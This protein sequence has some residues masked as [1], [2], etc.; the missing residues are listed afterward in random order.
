MELF[1][2]AT[3]FW[4]SEAITETKSMLAL[5]LVKMLFA[6]EKQLS[7]YRQRIEAHFE[8]HPDHDLFDSLTGAGPSW[9]L[10]CLPRSATILTCNRRTPIRSNPVVWR[11]Y[12][13]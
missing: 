7:E 11:T 3:E 10:V 6:L 9:L 12:L 13:R 5:S 2:K 1:A 4:G 8:S